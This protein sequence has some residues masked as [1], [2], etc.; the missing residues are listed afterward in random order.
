[1]LPK[2]PFPPP[3]SKV[4]PSDRHFTLVLSRYRSPTELPPSLPDPP[5]WAPKTL[6][7]E[8]LL[9]AIRQTRPRL[10]FLV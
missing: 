4:G 7:G 1:V 5:A 10:V 2:P 9:F 8:G 3:F 6:R